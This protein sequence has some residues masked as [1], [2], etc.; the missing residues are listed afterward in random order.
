[1]NC[2]GLLEKIRTRS[3]EIL[4]GYLDLPQVTMD[5]GLRY[6][7]GLSIWSELGGGAGSGLVGALILLQSAYEE[8]VD[9]T[10]TSVK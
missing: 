5:E 6:F 4:N 1:M 2:N 7:I 3:R 8:I 10:S 9:F